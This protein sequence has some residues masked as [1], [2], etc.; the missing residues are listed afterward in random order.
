MDEATENAWPLRP[1]LLAAIGA[2]AGLAIHLVL[3]ENDFT[4]DA[5]ALDIACAALIG[6]AATLLAFTLER[7][8][9]PW[10]LGFSAVAALVI[11]LVCYWNGAPDDWRTAENWRAV[12]GLLAVAIAAPLFQAARDA[13]A[14]RFDYRAVHDHAWTNVV[15]WCAGWAFVGIV[16]LLALLLSELFFLIKIAL[17]RDAL[18]EQWFVLMLIGTAL[19]AA[20]GVLR[21]RER[22]VRLLLNVVVA[23][24]GVLA[25]VLGAGL[26]LFLLSLPFTGLDALWEATRS[27]TPILLCCVIGALI[28]A[29]AVIGRDA[30]EESRFPPLL[31]GALALA[32]TMLPLAIIAAIST[33]TR[34]Q[35]YGYTP[36]RLWAVVFAIVALAYGIAYLAAVLRHR[37]AWAGAARR[38]N[39]GLGFGLCG[40]ALALALPLLSFNAIATRDQL[41]RL[42]SGRV[43]PEKFDWA[44]LR[45]DFGDPGKAAVAR[46]A[47]SGNPAIRTAAARSLKA[48]DRYD[49]DRQRREAAALETFDR[50]LTILPAGAELPPELRS[51]L[52]DWMVCS[53]DERCAVLY[54]AA[55][56]EAIA[57]RQS[58]DPARLPDAEPGKAPATVQF[59]SADDRCDPRVTRLRR[60]GGEWRT[61]EVAAPAA[62]RKAWATQVT[63]ALAAGR[64]EIRPVTRRQIFIDGRPAGAVFE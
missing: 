55:R 5:S 31:W 25:P 7:E 9:W 4:H 63:R 15:M 53:T 20:T 47:K 58:C 57:A 29:N 50:R 61:D 22:I 24:L 43:T 44:A 26:V 51:K 35:Q 64:I 3:G 34:I 1:W 54:D 60:I 16:F 23:V 56:S 45:F 13:G 37:L 17:L 46:L 41:A 28:L 12:C 59:A 19:G 48:E 52:T 2:A 30:A 11:A 21:E 33:G 42:E 27:T 8:R 40:L 14:R 62:A 49:A 39:L 36:D 32:V 38:I 10:A 18:R 6:S